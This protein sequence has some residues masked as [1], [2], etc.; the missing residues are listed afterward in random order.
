MIL[1]GNSAL[2][3]DIPL[4]PSKGHVPSFDASLFEAS[5][6]LSKA[7]IKALEEFAL[8]CSFVEQCKIARIKR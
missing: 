3:I 8:S 6:R 4:T 2:F 5:A 1:R 7:C